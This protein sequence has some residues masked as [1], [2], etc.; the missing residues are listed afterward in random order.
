MVGLI[1]SQK[2]KTENGG[3]GGKMKCW[4]I[5]L[6]EDC[7]NIMLFS[8]LEEMAYIHRQFFIC[9]HLR[10]SIGKWTV[11][12]CCNCWNHN[13]EW[14]QAYL[15]FLICFSDPCNDWN[16]WIDLCNHCNC[17]PRGTSTVI[18]SRNTHLQSWKYPPANF[19]LWL[20]S[21]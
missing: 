10:M 4:E 5:K 16:D 9:D 3:G 12:N 17:N 11:R 7:V 21:N 1:A 6:S 2:L 13:S 14:L 15:I 8:S 18:F 20:F 19:Y